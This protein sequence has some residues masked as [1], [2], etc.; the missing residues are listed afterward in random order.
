[1]LPCL[2]SELYSIGCILEV[3]YPKDVGLGHTNISI[4]LV[5]WWYAFLRSDFVHAV[6]AKL[7]Q[8]FLGFIY[9]VFVHFFAGDTEPIKMFD[10]TANLSNNQIIN[11]KCDPSEKW[12]VLIGIA[13][14]S[15]EVCCVHTGK[16]FCSCTRHASRLSLVFEAT[17][18]WILSTSLFFLGLEV[19]VNILIVISNALICFLTS[20]D[21]FIV[22]FVTPTLCI[23]GSCMFFF[24]FFF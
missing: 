22:A 10:R 19:V 5:Y 15:P 18:I 20:F 8:I 16:L 7:T 21:L 23:C 3:D 11:Y 1:M 4:S 6:H 14:G 17:C 24:L 9:L 12:L 2:F 13:P